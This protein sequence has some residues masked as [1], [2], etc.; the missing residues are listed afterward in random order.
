LATR[1]SW[2]FLKYFMAVFEEVAEQTQ[3]LPG[4]RSRVPPEGQRIFPVLVVPKRALSALNSRLF[5][6]SAKTKGAKA[7]CILYIKDSP[8]TATFGRSPFKE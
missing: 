8:T 2:G 7:R 1:A 3:G 5:Y 6:K 4:R